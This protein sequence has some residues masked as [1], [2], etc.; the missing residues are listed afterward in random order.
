MFA[1]ASTTLHVYAHQGVKVSCVPDR[2]HAVMTKLGAEGF[3]SVRHLLEADVSST[4]PC[5]WLDTSYF[6]RNEQH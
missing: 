2:L 4:R 3:R 5:P 6:T 1:I